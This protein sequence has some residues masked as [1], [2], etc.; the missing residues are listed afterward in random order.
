MK[1]IL[2]LLKVIF[3]FLLIQS[4]ALCKLPDFAVFGSSTTVIDC[5]DNLIYGLKVGLTSLDAYIVPIGGASLHIIKSFDPVCDT[6][7]V[8][9][10]KH[11]G[12]T[13]NTFNTFEVVIFGDVNGDGNIDAI[14]AGRIVD[15]ENNMLIWNPAKEL[16]FLRA[17]D[18]NGDNNFDSIDAGFVF[19]CEYYQKTKN[20]ITVLAN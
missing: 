3:V 13:F 2:Y 20:Q 9:N 1:K 15:Y 5:T 14:D 12:V 6:G 16:C 7:T 8:V 19:D 10:I 17:A 11:N 18:V 4:N